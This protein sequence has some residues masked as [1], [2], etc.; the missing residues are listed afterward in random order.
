[1]ATLNELR[2]YLYYE[3]SS[4]PYTGED[5]KQFQNKYINYLRSICRVNGWELVNVGRNHYCFTAFIKDGYKYVY[6]SISDVRG[7]NNEWYPVCAAIPYKPPAR[8][9]PL[10]ALRSSFPVPYYIVICIPPTSGTRWGHPRH[11]QG[12]SYGDKTASANLCKVCKDL[13]ISKLLLWIHREK[14]ADA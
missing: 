13:E 12:Q 5:Y 2:H 11:F 8:A 9:R 4:G 7:R 10:P 1:M 6:I 14:K 3:F